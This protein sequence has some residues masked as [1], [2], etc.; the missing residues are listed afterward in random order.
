[1]YDVKG[2][3]QLKVDIFPCELNINS[4]QKYFQNSFKG[5]A[6]TVKLLGLPRCVYVWNHQIQT[7]LSRHALLLFTQYEV[8]AL[9]AAP[10]VTVRI[11]NTRIHTNTCTHGY[12]P[13][14]SSPHSGRKLSRYPQGPLKKERVNKVGWVVELEGVG[15]SSDGDLVTSLTVNYSFWAAGLQL[16]KSYSVFSVREIESLIWALAHQKQFVVE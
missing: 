2:Q 16:R 6:V 3:S 5:R 4:Y 9:P 14:F 8:T 1:M 15:G 7:N 13:S 10:W 11:T 12:R